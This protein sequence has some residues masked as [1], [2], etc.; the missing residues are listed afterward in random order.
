M[1]AL[2]SLFSPYVVGVAARVNAQ[3]NGFVLIMM[4][5]LALDLGAY[6]SYAIPWAAQ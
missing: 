5:L 6:G 2:C 4:A 3:I 1:N